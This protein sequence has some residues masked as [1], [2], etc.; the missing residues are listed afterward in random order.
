[1]S[2]LRAIEF[3]LRDSVFN[4]EDPQPKNPEHSRI[5]ATWEHDNIVDVPIPQLKKTA[6]GPKA[7]STISSI[8]WVLPN[9][10]GCG[11]SGRRLAFSTVFFLLAAASSRASCAAARP[12]C[13]TT[14]SVFGIRHQCGVERARPSSG[15]RRR[16]RLGARARSHHPQ[17]GLLVGRA[18]HFEVAVLK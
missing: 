7:P 16:E 6:I 10:K 18:F 13:R 11:R 5:L 1:L 9:C 15:A 8:G 3:Y 4:W 17:M 12:R 14:R 2:K